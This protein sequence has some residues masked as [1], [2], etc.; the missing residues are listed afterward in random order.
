MAAHEDRQEALAAYA[1]GALDE[2][3]RPALEA[4]LLTC[5]GCRAALD[6][7]RLVTQGIALAVE[8]VAPPAGLRDRV[9]AQA[10]LDVRDANNFVVETSDRVVSVRTT[11]TQLAPFWALT[12]AAGLVIAILS[13]AYAWRMNHALEASRS[14]RAE[15][16]ARL[17]L[18]TA[19]DVTRVAL[20]G[21][22]D[23]PA[24]SG[25]AYLSPSH[26]LVFT[27]Q[28]LPAL[29]SGRA[30]QLWIVTAKAPMS[31]GML[32]VA[33]DGHVMVMM[34]M[35][36]GMNAA[37]VAVAVTIEPEGGVPAPTGAKVL[38]GA[39]TPQ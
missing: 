11:T 2:R 28:S 20:A 15:L 21:Q 9:L 23:A 3:D 22:P 4:H 33:P 10:T 1:L 37:M 18:V 17:M 13:G 14:E 38:V 27:A 39:V 6:E 8:P 19:T 16:E 25:R 30:Y 24:A 29:P 7:L 5:A 34:P 35:P 26:G 36:A 32:P 12:A 31:V